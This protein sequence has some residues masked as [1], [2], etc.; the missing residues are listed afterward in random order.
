LTSPAISVTGLHKTYGNVVALDEVC[1]E[2]AD[3]TVLGLLGPNGSGKTTTVSILS[4]AL[5]PDSGQARVCGF[6]VRSQG[7]AV[8]RVIGFA[9]QFAAVDA[10]LTGRENLALI[11]RLSRLPRAAARD[12]ARE[13]L[14]GFG[15]A[16]A[17]DRLVRTYSGGMRRRLDVAAAL[18][19]H[20]PV[21]F[22]DEPTTGLDPESRFALW[23]SVRE[24]VGAGTTVLLTTQYLEEADALADRIVILGSGRVV[25][26]GTPADL[27][28]RAGAVV[29]QLGFAGDAAAV[30][31]EHV[32]DAAG[33]GPERADS[34]VRVSSAGGSGA[35]VA[36]LRALDGLAPDPASVAVHEPTLDDVFLALTGHAA[37]S[38]DQPAEAQLG[39]A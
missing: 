18:V 12:R 19:H 35:L 32:L 14:A 8:R 16:A 39:A 17:A 10:N 25:E 15:L 6:D 20:P 3:G 36:V 22:L 37:T 2:V 21:L 23:K 38:H 5:R 24:L 7:A 30:Q 34:T 11:G 28:A 4:T 13:L 1:F 33:F 26:V 9:G 31:A 29:F 27:K